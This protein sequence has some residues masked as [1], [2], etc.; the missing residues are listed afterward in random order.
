MTVN[1][2]SL[3]DS[4]KSWAL[5]KIIFPA[6]FSADV[7]RGEAGKEMGSEP[8]SAYFIY[9]HGKLDIRWRRIGRNRIFITPY[10]TQLRTLK[11]FGIIYRIDF[12]SRHG[13]KLHGTDISISHKADIKLQIFSQK[14]FNHSSEMSLEF[15]L[16]TR[17]MR[18]NREKMN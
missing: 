5:W 11:R 9:F 6:P 16:Q 8:L 10:N 17:P 15:L 18:E 2:K 13:R 12:Q 14:Q 1:N 3:N 7:G 4:I